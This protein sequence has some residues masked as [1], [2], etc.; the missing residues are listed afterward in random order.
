MKH[1]V[2]SRF[3]GDVRF[4]AEIDCPD[5]APAGIKLRLAVMWAIKNRANLSGADLSG[6]YLSGA[7]LYRADLSGA[8]LSGANLSG[9]Y[10]SGAY[11]SG[12]DLYRADLSGANLY[13]ADL[14]GAN[15]S[16]A[17]LIDGGEDKR[18]YRFW[19]WRRK[20]GALII[21]GGCR[22][23]AGLAAATAHYGKMYDSDGDK[24][25]CLARIALIEAVARQRGWLAAAEGGG[26][27]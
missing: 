25:E 10:L 19:A 24:A 18:G 8:D 16:G 27:E 3:T 20:D 5:D 13:R 4:T 23:W 1:D 15:L 11:L 12:A 17:D 6:A 26:D 2:K 14:S 9:A 21:R 22:E 7:D